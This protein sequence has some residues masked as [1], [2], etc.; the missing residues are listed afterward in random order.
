MIGKFNDCLTPL[1]LPIKDGLSSKEFL[2]VRCGRC[3][4]CRIHR[5]SE[6]SLRLEMESKYWDNISFLTLTYNSENLPM[7]DYFD[8]RLFLND[9]D[10]EELPEFSECVCFP[11]LAYRDL[12]LFIKRLRKYQVGEE[13]DFIVNTEHGFDFEHRIGFKFFGVGEYGSKRLRPHLHILLFGVEAN[14]FNSEICRKAW[15]KGHILL[16]P[17]N[18]HTCN[19]VAGY[20][21][22]KLYGDKQHITVKL[23]EFM[24]CSQFLGWQWIL[25]NLKY[26]D[27]HHPYINWQ[28]K[29]GKSFQYGIPRT[30]R[31]KLVEMGKLQKTSQS[32]LAFQQRLEYMALVKDLNAKGTELSDFFRQRFK[33]ALDKENKK[34]VG[35]K[36]TGEI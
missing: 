19:Y 30:F 13:H 10:I 3:I 26:I 8:S 18:Q 35:R 22:K 14:A 27:E 20:V 5:T 31:K 9:K 7:T 2:R 4:N 11:T 15:N 29:D 32:A 28:G 24:R 25:D 34:Q 6:W 23:P 16:K 21:Q 33:L 12:P 1:Y 36:L 17:F